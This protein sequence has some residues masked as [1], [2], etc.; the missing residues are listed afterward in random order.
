M[1]TIRDISW[2]AG[3]VE[4]EGCFTKC[5]ESIRISVAMTDQDTVNKVATVWGTPVGVWT[6]R[7]SNKTPYSTVIC[8]NAAAGWMMTLYPLLG[9]R[10]QARIRELLKIWRDKKPRYGDNV[11]CGHLDRP[12]L[13]LGKCSTCYGRDKARRLRS[14]R[15][16]ENL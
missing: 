2:L 4:G 6:T 1:L 15:K 16:R 12:H 13:A 9:G 5:R 14:A 7:G 3:L 8:G 10:R 11:V